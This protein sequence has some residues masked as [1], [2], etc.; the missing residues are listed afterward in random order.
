MRKIIRLIIGSVILGAI[1]IGVIG[2]IGFVG[3]WLMEDNGRYLLG[4]GILGY[5]LYRCFKAEFG[6]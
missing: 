2:L 1:I 6:E 4:I 5:I 3:E